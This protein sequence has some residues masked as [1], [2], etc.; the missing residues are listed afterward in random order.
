MQCMKCGIF[1][2]VD[3]QKTHKH[4]YR[5]DGITP[6]KLKILTDL[7]VTSRNCVT[8]KKKCHQNWRI[9]W[10]DPISLIGKPHWAPTINVWLSACGN[11]ASVERNSILLWCW[12]I[13]NLNQF[14]FG[15]VRVSVVAV[16]VAAF[17]LCHIFAA[18][19]F[20]KLSLW[21]FI[22]FR[23]IKLPTSTEITI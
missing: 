16:V 21:K 12:K 9:R 20:R 1:I 8:W 14:F 4:R 11:A 10:I 17:R 2:L 7:R 6:T 3:T 22:S 18:F 5:N 15:F 13:Y 23:F 19:D